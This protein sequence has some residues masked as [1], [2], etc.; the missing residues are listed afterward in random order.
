MYCAV[1]GC[2]SQDSKKDRDKGIRLLSFPR[3]RDLR[4]KWKNAC[5]RPENFNIYKN[6]I[7]S[8][9]FSDDVKEEVPTL[10]LPAP[11][12]FIFDEELIDQVKQHDSLYN[13][14]HPLYTN[15]SAKEKAWNEIAIHLNSNG[16]KK[17]FIFQ[18]LFAC[19]LKKPISSKYQ[20]TKKHE[21]IRFKAACLDGWLIF[22]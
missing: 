22:D 17:Y 18:I 10:N 9:H 21:N 13:R 6:R 16:K 11:F 8:L 14:K 3:G 15:A 4:K 7:C 12:T 5:R 20:S 2:K 19:T 1:L